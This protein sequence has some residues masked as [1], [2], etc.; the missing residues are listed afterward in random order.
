MYLVTQYG[1]RGRSVYSILMDLTGSIG[2]EKLTP[3][4]TFSLLSIMAKVGLLNS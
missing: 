1:G 4:K 2:T 3:A